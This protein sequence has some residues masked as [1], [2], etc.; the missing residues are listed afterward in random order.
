[1]LTVIIDKFNLVHFLNLAFYPIFGIA[2]YFIF[3]K[4]SQKTKSIFLWIIL[5]LA[6]VS[7][8]LTFATDLITD[9]DNQRLHFWSRLPLHMCSINVILYPL[10]YGI[11]NKVKP[12]VSSTLFAYMYFVGSPGALLAMVFAPGDCIGASINFFSYNVFTYWLKHGLIFV[13]PILMVSLGQY[14]PKLKDTLKASVF[15]LGLLI[16]MEGV[17]L[18]FSWFGHLNGSSNISNFFYTRTGVGTPILETF[19]NLIPIELIYMLPLV[20]IAIPIFMVY[21]LPVL[22]A[23]AIN[24]KIINKKVK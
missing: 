7:T 10:F 24:H 2:C 14:K 8:W 19:Y 5:G 6:F 21:Y 3:K 9:R 1:M 15:L 16:V 23:R 22:L 4:S 20:V 18:L 17:N 13:I 12:L 11:R